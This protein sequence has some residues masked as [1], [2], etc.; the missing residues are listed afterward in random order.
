MN[1]VTTTMAVLAALGLL[2][3]GPAMAQ[4]TSDQPAA[5]TAGGMTQGGQATAT[6]VSDEDLREY[7]RVWR[8][9]EEGDENQELKR[10]LQSGD[11][12]GHEQDLSTALATA[13]SS[14][15]TEEFEQVHRQVQSDPSLQARME[16]ETGVSTSGAQGQTS[17]PGQGAPLPSGALGT[18]PS[19]V[20]GGTPPGTKEPALGQGA[21]AV[22]GGSQGDAGSTGTSGASGGSSGG[23]K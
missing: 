1:P 20:E 17:R 3:A 2:A 13:G 9:I 21:P 18:G 22:P 12:Q 15:T 11:L 6:D 8:Q 10:A 4:S 16:R 7:A 23:T 5:G 14:M 19:S